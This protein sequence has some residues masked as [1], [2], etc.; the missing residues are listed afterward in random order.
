MCLCV[1]NANEKMGFH[2][3]DSAP[4]AAAARVSANTGSGGR[5]PQSRRTCSRRSSDRSYRDRHCSSLNVARHP[6][7]RESEASKAKSSLRGGE[8][9]LAEYRGAITE[10][11]TSSSRRA[12]EGLQGLRLGRLPASTKLTSRKDRQA[13]RS[14][15]NC[16]LV[17]PSQAPRQVVRASVARRHIGNP[18]FPR[19]PSR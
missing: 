14:L 7:A 6:P 16:A 19:W 8:R 5:H 18:S 11:R 1:L 3:R 12:P 10:T 2:R 15:F 17:T 9:R 13:P 4:Q